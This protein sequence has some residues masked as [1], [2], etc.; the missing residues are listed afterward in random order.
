MIK[1]VLWAILFW[2]I[3]LCGYGQLPPSPRPQTVAPFSQIYIQGSID[4]VLHT[5]ALH[6]QII[7]RGDARD[8]SD[9]IWSVNN[10]ILRVHLGKGFPKYGRIQVELCTTTLSSFVYQGAGTITGK[11]INSNGLD[12]KIDNKGKAFLDGHIVLR[13]LAIKGTGFTQ[14][15]GIVSRQIPIKIAGS[16]RVQLSGVANMT[17]VELKD[18]AWFS[19]YWVKSDVLVVRAKESAFIQLAGIAKM[20][21][22]ELWGRARFNGRYLRAT[23]SFVKTH[24]H[25]E[26]DI[27]IVKRQHTLATDASNIYFYNL[28]EMKA[29]FMAIN[30]AVLDMREWENPYFTE[31]T[32]YNS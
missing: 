32:R 14:I 31:P 30:G 13:T 3:S 22:V 8:L 25:A 1:P 21:D 2:S 10:G 7:L 26:A 4:V 18:T 17:T 16:Q 28:P 23:R 24:G 15:N 11:N 27:A 29:D 5:G 6:P 9:V 20:L 12:V 19:L